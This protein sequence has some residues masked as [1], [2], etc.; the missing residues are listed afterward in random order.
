MFTFIGMAVCAVAGIVYV[1][2]IPYTMLLMFCYGDTSGHWLGKV[3]FSLTWPI[4]FF[5]GAV[6]QFVQRWKPW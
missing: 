5:G 2:G 6:V 1:L 4:W 3:G